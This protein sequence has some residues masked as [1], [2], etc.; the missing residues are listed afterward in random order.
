MKPKQPHDKFFKE[1]F[2]RIE[3]ARDY[4]DQ[5]LPDDIRQNLDLRTLQLSETSHVDQELQEHLSD[6]VYSCRWKTHT[7]I[8]ISLLFEH[9]SYPE[10]YPHIQL[11]RY[12]LGVWEYD[13]REEKSL[14]ITIPIIVYHGK[15]KWKY[16]AFPSYFP[17]YPKNSKQRKNNQKR[18]TA[19][20]TP[21]SRYIPQFAYHLTDLSN[22]PDEQILALKMGFLVNTFLAL[23]HKRDDAYIK[24]NFEQL[25]VYAEQYLETEKGRNFLEVVVVYILQ[26]TELKREEVVKLVHQLPKP[27]NK[28]TMSTYDMI[29]TE[30]IKEGIQKGI[31]K[32]RIATLKAAIT[33]ILRK[34]P[35]WSNEEIAELTGASIEFV[36]KIKKDLA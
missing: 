4:I 19:T 10:Q 32:G 3:V 14:S 26:T 7:E 9:K 24:A 11:L 8:R 28:L 31:Q 13:I 6:I 29:K 36:Q 33:R 27:L 16:K 23:K 17:L 1:T 5:F 18:L 30:G 12:L 35:N 20:D 25:F 15:Q 22:Y 34:Y 21:L 2:S